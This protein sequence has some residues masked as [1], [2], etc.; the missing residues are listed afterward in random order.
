MR[1]T[2]G[3]SLK[4]IISCY[5]VVLITASLEPMAAENSPSGPSQILDQIQTQLKK[6][7]GTGPLRCEISDL[8]TL[9]RPSDYLN[10]SSVGGDNSGLANYIQSLADHSPEFQDATKAFY[11]DVET[12]LK[13]QDAVHVHTE[14]L[15]SGAPPVSFN[16][17]AGDSNHSGL[18][19][20]WL[21]DLALM[22]S[23]GNPNLAM[24]LI[25]VC[26]NDDTSMGSIVVNFSEE[27]SKQRLSERT[28]LIDEA[29]QTIKT[30]LTVQAEHPF[31][32]KSK[33]PPTNPAL[34]KIPNLLDQNNGSTNVLFS[35]SMQGMIDCSDTKAEALVNLNELKTYRKGLNPDS[36]SKGTMD[37]PSF[38]TQGMPDYYLPKS[39]GKNADIS[40]SLKKRI[41]SAKSR[42]ACAGQTDSSDPAQCLQAKY[43]HV[44]AGALVACEMIARGH[45][46]L[47]IDELSV[48]MGLGYRA[49]ALSTLEARIKAQLS[50]LPSV[51]EPNEN[52]IKGWA[53]SLEE[54]FHL[55]RDKTHCELSTQYNNYSP[56]LPSGKLNP[57][58]DADALVLLRR[59]TFSDQIG[60]WIGAPVYTNLKIPFAETLSYDRPADWSKQR[61]DAAKAEFDAM[62]VDFDWTAEQHKVGALFAASVC[63]PDPE[64]IKNNACKK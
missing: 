7:R 10:S 58:V 33:C 44:Y 57:Q 64:K 3:Q 29:I 61:F 22:H 40:D 51:N 50:T 32:T 13:T 20:G 49:F 42:F 45:N 2:L 30:K 6:I 28:K 63:K 55:N 25:G 47:G 26:G 27:E 52:E 38:G 54:V 60:K 9:L 48:A 46:P 8:A 35:A 23:K 15:F 59:W 24:E 19:P 39:L 41:L 11:R 62:M 5:L 56:T 31:L 17:S 34:E 14:Q 43:Y 53:E 12:T 18:K 4:Y 37:C 16:Q 1:P 21:W 36:F